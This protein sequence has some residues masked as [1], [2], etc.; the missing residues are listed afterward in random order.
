VRHV[1]ATLFSG[2]ACTDPRDFEQI[3][4]QL[5]VP[6]ACCTQCDMLEAQSVAQKLFSLIPAP[7]TWLL[8]FTL[9][10]E[11]VSVLSELMDAPLGLEQA[12]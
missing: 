1:G 5:I 10:S 3:C 6:R 9:N 11:L 12:L 8:S 4:V 2:S 7:S